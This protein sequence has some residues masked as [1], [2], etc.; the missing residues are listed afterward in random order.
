M[1]S[2]ITMEIDDKTKVICNY[3]GTAFKDGDG[4]CR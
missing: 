3:T 4:T 1:K 2:A